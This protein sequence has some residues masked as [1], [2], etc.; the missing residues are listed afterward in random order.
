MRNSEHGRTLVKLGMAFFSITA[1]MSFASCKQANQRSEIKTLDSV[2]SGETNLKDNQCSGTQKS[3][4]DAESQIIFDKL[5]P[6]KPDAENEKKIRS[7]VTAYFTAIPE[8]M[9]KLFLDFGG[10][11]FISSRVDDLCSGSRSFQALDAQAL[12]KTEGCFAFATDPKNLKPAI[13]TLIQSP[14]STL[15]IQYYGPQL[16]GYLY[17]QFYS[18]VG[19]PSSKNKLFD[20]NQTEA[21]TLVLQKERVAN[22]FLEDMLK[23]KT[24]D[25]TVLSKILGKDAKDE[26]E[27]DKKIQPIDR[28]S[29]ASTGGDKAKRR[30]QVMDYFFANAFQSMHC[31]QHSKDLAFKYFTT[32]H[33]VFASVDEA[34]LDFSAKLSGS[35]SKREPESSKKPAPEKKQT[36]ASS[37]KSD[38]SLSSDDPM[39]MLSMLMPALGGGGGGRGAGGLASILGGGG[40]ADL[41]RKFSG[42][43]GGIPGIDKL[44]AGGGGRSAG[45]LSGVYS[46][47]SAGGCP[48]GSCPGGACNGS[49]SGGACSSC[50]NG[51]CGGCSGG[52][53][54]G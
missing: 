44:M 45:A 21:T 31:N 13:L 32:A 7:A 20:I 6:K 35:V 40:I 23:S 10:T 15:H 34:I 26:L 50:A 14:S 3:L 49:C 37:G 30:T 1:L 51:N 27:F 46:Q 41:F 47:L 25:F 36:V 18:R 38:F 11:V 29:F 8:P 4:I 19:E 9:Q 52:C 43:A 24:Y 2:A 33:D 12:E 53:S 22:A 5:D 54:C 39:D 17:A 48:G 42:G 16:F 28:L